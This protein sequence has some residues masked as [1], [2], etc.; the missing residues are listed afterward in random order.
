MLNPLAISFIKCLHSKNLPHPPSCMIILPYN[1]RVYVACSIFIHLFGQFLYLLDPNYC[2][3]LSALFWYTHSILMTLGCQGSKWE[4]GLDPQGDNV[5]KVVYYFGQM[6]AKL[7]NKLIFSKWLVSPWPLDWPRLSWGFF[8]VS[9]NFLYVIH[10]LFALSSCSVALGSIFLVMSHLYLP[11]STN[12][13]TSHTLTYYSIG[14]AEIY[15]FYGSAFVPYPVVVSFG[16]VLDVYITLS[17][18]MVMGAT[19]ISPAAL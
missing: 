6:P 11:S 9:I 16:D 7:T 4:S 12:L 10:Q 2:I 5:E 17:L 1:I 15:H 13:L 14:L 18:S 3:G 8:L 19:Q